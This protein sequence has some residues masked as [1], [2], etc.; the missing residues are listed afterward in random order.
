MRTIYMVGIWL[1]LWLSGCSPWSVS[2]SQ[3]PGTQ[4]PPGVLLAT[5]SAVDLLQCPDTS[6]T[7]IQETQYVAALAMTEA[8]LDS[9]IRS[10]V[11]YWASHTRSKSVG[12]EA[13]VAEF[14]DTETMFEQVL[15]TFFAAA[16]WPYANWHTTLNDLNHRGFLYDL[17]IHIPNIDQADTSLFPVF[18]TEVPMPDPTESLAADVI[19]GWGL[20]SDG[21]RLPLFIGESVAEN[22]VAPFWIMSLQI[23]DWDWNPQ[24]SE[25]PMYWAGKNPATSTLPP[26]VIQTLNL[27]ALQEESGQAEIYGQVYAQLPDQLVYRV[28]QDPEQFLLNCSATQMGQTHTLNKMITPHL[29]PKS[30]ICLN[31]YE[32]DWYAT[33]KAIGNCHGFTMMANMR[34]ADDWV[35]F[36]P[37]SQE[38]EEALGEPWLFLQPV[39]FEGGKGNMMIN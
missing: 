37:S 12:V 20:D 34:F 36:E 35:A 33:P 6:L 16:Q 1:T 22:M 8:A 4:I 3:F 7:I 38:V 17:V 15:D 11:H 21:S 14:P 28:L 24:P 26:R 31:V 10:F 39:N 9:T 19:W 2:S 5:Q 23:R 25:V 30:S 32:R 18:G 27:N 29:P 13:I